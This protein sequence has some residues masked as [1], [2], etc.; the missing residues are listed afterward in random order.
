M[1]F[2]FQ[3]ANKSGY[4]FRTHYASEMPLIAE[5]IM[6][7]KLQI[8]TVY[9]AVNPTL[10]TVKFGNEYCLDLLTLLSGLPYQISS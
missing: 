10:I 1:S 6:F 2:N 7:V 4:K 5:P 3:S 9:G 8:F